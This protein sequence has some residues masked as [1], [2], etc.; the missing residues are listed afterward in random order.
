MPRL[1]H[2]RHQ[3]ETGK[4]NRAYPEEHL[5]CSRQGVG[6]HRG[7]SADNERTNRRDNAARVVAETRARGAQSR[8]KEF[9]KVIGE[10]PE[11]SKNSQADEEV[12]IQTVVRRDVESE[13][14]H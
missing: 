11:N 9:W 1:D 5:H 13:R 7:D 14:R 6:A 12:S 10:G 3:Q 2:P 4:W 8:R